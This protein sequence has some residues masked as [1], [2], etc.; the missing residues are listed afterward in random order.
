MNLETL[1]SL[2]ASSLAKLLPGR[3]CPPGGYTR[4]PGFLRV[5]AVLYPP[6]PRN[7]PFSKNYGLWNDNKASIP[8][9]LHFSVT[10]WGVRGVRRYKPGAAWVFF[11]PPGVPP[12][13][14]GLYPPRSPMGLERCSHLKKSAQFRN[15]SSVS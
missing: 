2:V 10:G 3:T 13:P 15:R 6:L 8:S 11:V 5:S 7:P 4:T 1:R 12:V 14:D 9:L